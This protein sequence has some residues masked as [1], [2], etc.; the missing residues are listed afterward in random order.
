VQSRKKLPTAIESARAG[1]SRKASGTCVLALRQQ[2]PFLRRELYF[3]GRMYDLLVGV[4]RR[5]RSL[6]AVR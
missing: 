2:M 5:V 3:A 6:H 4:P 1:L